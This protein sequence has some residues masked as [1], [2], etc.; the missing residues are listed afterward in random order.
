MIIFFAE[1]SLAL[2]CI[3]TYATNSKH[4]TTDLL[5]R[6]Y[7]AERYK[8]RFS[9]YMPA[10]GILSLNSAFVSKKNFVALSIFHTHICYCDGVGGD[11]S[12]EPTSSL[13]RAFNTTLKRKTR[14]ARPLRRAQR[15]C[16]GQKYE[17]DQVSCW[18]TAVRITL[19]FLYNFN[20]FV[21]LIIQFRS[22]NT[23]SFIYLLDNIIYYLCIYLLSY[24]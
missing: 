1:A 8:G 11:R 7:C 22:R 16:A 21:H 2:R 20:G 9:N 5:N 3:P 24:I 23:F 15:T 14:T 12:T 4:A 18:A 19:K 17:I 6:Y 13:A 10:A